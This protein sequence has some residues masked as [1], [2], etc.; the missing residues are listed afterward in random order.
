MF[1]RLAIVAA[2]T[3]AALLSPMPLRAR[4]A[5]SPSMANPPQPSPRDPICDAPGDPSLVLNT[6]I[7]LGDDAKATLMKAASAAIAE[8]L[9]KPE[10]YVAVCINDGASVLFGGSDAPAALGC[11]YSIGAISQANNGAVQ[12]K[13]SSLLAEHAVPAD[14]I[15]IN[16]FDIPRA[17]CGWSG[18]TFAG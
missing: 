6:N 11:L 5:P 1:L 9:S 7:R 14:R 16:Y 15:Y 12:A 3:D 13:L 17:N 8:C 4:R 10:S 2:V 18:R